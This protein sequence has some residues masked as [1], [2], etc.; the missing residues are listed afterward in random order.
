MPSMLSIQLALYGTA[1]AKTA[2]DTV[3]EFASNEAESVKEVVFVLFD[4]K[5]YEA[6]EEALM[7]YSYRAS[8]PHSGSLE[9]VLFIFKQY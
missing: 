4:E 1:G 7:P 2:I 8:K 6:Y 3:V 9:T 5:T